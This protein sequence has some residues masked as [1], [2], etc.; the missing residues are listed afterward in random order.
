[1]RYDNISYSNEPTGNPALTSYILV[2]LFVVE[3]IS[4][5][6]LL[7]FDSIKSASVGIVLSAFLC[8][9]NKAGRG[10]S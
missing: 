2:I 9:Q 8:A 3:P 1:M 6:K 10:S 5:P 4:L 7:M